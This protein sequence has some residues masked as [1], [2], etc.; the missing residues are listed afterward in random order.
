MNTQYKLN[1]AFFTRA[2]VVYVHVHNSKGL[3]WFITKMLG[4]VNMIH[5]KR[6]PWF[7]IILLFTT[8]II[9]VFTYFIT[10]K[11]KIFDMFTHSFSYKMHNHTCTGTTMLSTCF[12][13][14]ILV[15]LIF[16]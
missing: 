7:L 12:I 13:I 15:T 14:F 5:K 1:L 8:A 3:H 10:F 9:D 11:F 4:L 16:D 2:F 6:L